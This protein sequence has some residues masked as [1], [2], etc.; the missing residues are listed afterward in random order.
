MHESLLGPTEDS[1]SIGK[2][3]VSS[4]SIEWWDREQDIHA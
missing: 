1:K 3:D 2:E 4:R